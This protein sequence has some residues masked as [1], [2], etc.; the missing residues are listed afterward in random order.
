MKLKDFIKRM[1]EEKQKG[2]QELWDSLIDYVQQRSVVGDR[3]IFIHL[4]EENMVEIQKKHNLRQGLQ[5]LVYCTQCKYA[6]ETNT[7]RDCNFY[8]T[9][10]YNFE[11]DAK[12]CKRFKKRIGSGGI[13]Q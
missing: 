7:D 11:Y 13:D 4:E 2:K 6:E 5:I 8:C 1:K 9:L 12:E 3:S 10:G